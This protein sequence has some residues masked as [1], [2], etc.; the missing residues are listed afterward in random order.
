[1]RPD[2]VALAKAIGGGIPASAVGGTE[3]VMRVYLDGTLEGEG[4]FNGNPLSMAAARVVLSEILTPDVYERFENQNARFT[5]ALQ[6]VVTRHDLPATVQTVR[7]RGSV[8]FRPEPVRN[9][10]D[11][12]GADGKL[13]HLAWLYQ[14]N[15][16]VFPPAGDPW[17]FSVAHNDADL[18]RYAENLET[19]ADA[20]TA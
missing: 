12:A 20:V 9:F 8:H 5:S 4:T 15:G 19:F 18:E 14:L 16:G 10:R 1:V 11:E 7:C 6:D 2:L 17:T 13:Q 3:E